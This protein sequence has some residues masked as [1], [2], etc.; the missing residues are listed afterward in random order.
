MLELE[1]RKNDLEQREV[2][3]QKRNVSIELNMLRLRQKP[4]AQSE[5]IDL[6]ASPIV[7]SSIKSEPLTPDRHD[8]VSQNRRVQSASPPLDLE[9]D[10]QNKTQHPVAVYELEA[11]PVQQQSESQV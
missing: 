6:T 9:P 8:Q 10:N 11:I 2:G 7:E 1:K 5:L 4:T 3:L